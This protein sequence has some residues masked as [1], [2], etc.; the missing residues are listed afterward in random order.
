MRGPQSRTFV[1][2][3]PY[4][5]SFLS[6]H[7]HYTFGRCPTRTTHTTRL[8]SL[9]RNYYQGGLSEPRE[10]ILIPR[11]CTN[12]AASLIP[13]LKRATFL[14]AVEAIRSSKSD[15]GAAAFEAA[16]VDG[17]VK[18]GSA[19][20]SSSSSSEDDGDG[21]K[22][23]IGSDSSE[24]LE[25]ERDREGRSLAVIEEA[26]ALQHQLHQLSDDSSS[27]SDVTS[28]SHGSVS[29]S[30]DDE[31]EEEEEE[32]TEDFEGDG[33]GGDGLDDKQR[34]IRAQRRR[35]AAENLNRARC[36]RKEAS[37]RYCQVKRAVARRHRQRKEQQQGGGGGGGLRSAAAWSGLMQER[38]ESARV[39]AATRTSTA[40]HHNGSGQWQEEMNLCVRLFLEAHWLAAHP[41]CRRGDIAGV[42]VE[43]EALGIISKPQSTTNAKESR[44]DDA[45]E[46]NDKKESSG[47]YEEKKEEGVM[48]AHAETN[49]KEAPSSKKNNKDVQKAALGDDKA[50]HALGCLSLRGRGMARD[51][52]K[53]TRYFCHAVR[54]GEARAALAAE[55]R[56]RRERRHRLRQRRGQE[57]RRHLHLEQEDGAPMS[58]VFE[59]EED[60]EGDGEGADEGEDSCVQKDQAGNISS[61]FGD[62]NNDSDV[63]IKKGG[64]EDDDGRGHD[65]RRTAAPLQVKGRGA[66]RSLCALATLAAGQNPRG[67]LAMYVAAAEA[68]CTSALVNLADLRR[69]RASDGSG[70]EQNDD[71][72]EDGGD[73]VAAYS[74]CADLYEKVLVEAAKSSTPKKNTSTFKSGANSARASAKAAFNLGAMFQRGLLDGT[75]YLHAEE[76]GGHHHHH[77]HHHHLHHDHHDQHHGHHSGGGSGSAL[78]PHFARARELYASAGASARRATETLE[79]G[80]DD[81]AAT[82]VGGGAKS[83]GGGRGGGKGG[84]IGAVGLE[85]KAAERVAALDREA[86][87]SRPPPLLHRRCV[88]LGLKSQPQLNGATG[89]AASFDVQRGRYVLVLDGGG[90]SGNKGGSGSETAKKA[91]TGSVGINDSSGGNHSSPSLPSASSSS[92]QQRKSQSRAAVAS[93]GLPRAVKLRPRNLKLEPGAFNL[94]VI[95]GSKPR[96]SKHL[97]NDPSPL[98]E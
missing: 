47:N 7:H 15:G 20:G 2:P 91:S 79:D 83:G 60:G 22:N 17:G 63:I 64:T 56:R 49:E 1:H 76:R 88:V 29:L 21:D 53:A 25:F 94:G 9:I 10:I 80:H 45:E 6:H 59:V 35:R 26:F 28:S 96:T 44:G 39:L 43:S 50:L 8:L 97:P 72:N 36:L 34:I 57:R 12:E 3:H 5:C 13:E 33:E 19:T 46:G 55:R 54:I 48:A 92:Q 31:V 71:C 93:S 84:R 65:Q 61:A 51:P 18:F 85:G 37:R 98:D 30:D 62:S 87:R 74:K 73:L 32:D 16:Q 81:N 78:P 89:I 90:G 75:H 24:T 86:H 38:E 77:H 23:G 11:K 4:I 42:D 58:V 70:T 67:A 68:G 69:R 95:G 82:A 66:A 41:L 40:G 52:K 27:S 14:K